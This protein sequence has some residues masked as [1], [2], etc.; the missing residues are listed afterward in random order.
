[1]R[2][3]VGET[4]AQRLGWGGELGAELGYAYERNH[5]TNWATANMAPYMIAIE[6]GANRSLF[7]DALN[8]NY[9]AH[10]VSLR[11]DFKW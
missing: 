3:N 2:Y 5:M 6:A 11:L 7:L 9:D 1:L 10:I 4:L 8:P